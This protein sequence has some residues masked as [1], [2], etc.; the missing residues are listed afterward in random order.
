MVQSEAMTLVQTYVV[1]V[2]S[3]NVWNVYSH[4]V[5]EDTNKGSH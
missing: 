5:D 4:L 1:S 3:S 2:D